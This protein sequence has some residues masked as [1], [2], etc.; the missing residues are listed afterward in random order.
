LKTIYAI[1]YYINSNT[2]SRTDKSNRNSNWVENN[3]NQRNTEGL[4][5]I[6]GKTSDNTDHTT[7]QHTKV[8]LVSQNVSCGIYMQSYTTEA[9]Q[10]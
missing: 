2:K 8:G 7:I 9:L 5:C 10:K 3:T 4:A 1:P 6:S